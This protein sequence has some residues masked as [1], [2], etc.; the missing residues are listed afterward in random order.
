M[1]DPALFV[2]AI[3][4]VL[5][6]VMFSEAIAELV[7]TLLRLAVLAWAGFVFVGFPVI[8]LYRIF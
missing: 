7:G 2:G 3:I 4:V 5:L 8:V 1:I 6:L